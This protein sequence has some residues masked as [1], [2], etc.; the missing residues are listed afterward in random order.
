MSGL[1]RNLTI[2]PAHSVY[3]VGDRLVCEAIG[4]P[5]PNYYWTELQTGKVMSESVLTIDDYMRSD[6][7]HSFQCTA[8]NTVAGS[9]KQISTIITFTVAGSNSYQSIFSLHCKIKQQVEVENLA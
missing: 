4:N 8:Y 6:Q 3:E 5:K 1:S 9:R 2:T 7:N